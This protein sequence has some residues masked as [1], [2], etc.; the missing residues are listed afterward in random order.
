[1]SSLIDALYWR[2]STKKFDPSKKISDADLDELL[3]SLRLAPSSYGLQPW[4][5]Y[6]VT[7]PAIRKELSQPTGSHPQLTDASHLLVLCAKTQMDEA[8][9]DQYVQ[10]MGKVRGM[11]AEAM[12]K[13]KERYIS[14]MQ[15]KSP[16]VM[17]EWTKKQVYIALG[18]LLTACALKKVDSCPM[19][20]FDV[21]KVNELLGL[22]K[23]GYTATLLCPIGYRS[24]DDEHAQKAKV[25]F[26][27]E[28]VSVRM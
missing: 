3:E 13:S 15:S 26:P 25:R 24:A 28:D 22:G 8:H 23:D 4:K 19:E 7:D 12:H 9:I 11:D 14:R 5:F 2:Y 16:E 6:V 10:L 17:N 1:M 21:E 18:M 27:K 20:G